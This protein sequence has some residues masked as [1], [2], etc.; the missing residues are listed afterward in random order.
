MPGKGGASTN[1]GGPGIELQ[2]H[3]WIEYKE[4]LD[5]CVQSLSHAGAEIREDKYWDCEE[6]RLEM[7]EVPWWA[8]EFSTTGMV[9]ELDS[10]AQ[11]K[12]EKLAEHNATRTEDD[13]IY[14]PQPRRGPAAELRPMLYRDWRDR[15]DKWSAA[16]T[17]WKEQYAAYKSD[18]GKIVTMIFYTT[19][20]DIKDSVSGDPEWAAAMRASDSLALHRL[21]R[22]H[23][24][25][26]NS[27]NLDRYVTEFTTF[28]WDD[29]ESI[30]SNINR[31]E[32]L[33]RA[34]EQGGKKFT[35]TEMVTYLTR[36][37]PSSLD[38][39]TVLY[40]GK[41]VIEPGDY[42][43]LKTRIRTMIG[44]SIITAGAKPNKTKGDGTR[45]LAVTT[46]GRDGSTGRDQRKGKKRP[47]PPPPP[48]TADLQQK[49]Q[50]QLGSRHEKEPCH[51]CGRFG[52]LRG[53]CQ[54]PIERCTECFS[55]NHQAKYCNP[56]YKEKA[57]K[58][59]FSATN[60]Q[61]QPLPGMSFGGR[62]FAFLLTIPTAAPP[63]TGFDGRG[64]APVAYH[65]AHNA[66][67]GAQ[68]MPAVTEQPD[69]DEVDAEEQQGYADAMET[70][71]YECP[72]AV[73]GLDD[74]EMI[75]E[76]ESVDQ[77]DGS[78]EIVVATAA[79]TADSNGGGVDCDGHRVVTRSSVPYG[80]W[81]PSPP[82]RPPAGYYYKAH[83]T[84][85]YP[86]PVM[87]YMGK[88]GTGS[89]FEHP[90]DLCRKA[91]PH[92]AL[93][94]PLDTM[95]P[96]E[97]GMN[98]W[99]DEVTA[100]ERAWE[101]VR[102][103]TGMGP[104]QK[105]GQCIK[106]DFPSLVSARAVETILTLEGGARP[107]QARKA[108][109]A[110]A[111]MR[112]R[113]QTIDVR[114]WSTLTPRE[115]LHQY[116]VLTEVP[117]G[118]YVSREA[119][120]EWLYW[121]PNWGPADRAVTRVPERHL[122][123]AH[124]IPPA[125]LRKPY[126]H[127]HHWVAANQPELFSLID[128]EPNLAH[129]EVMLLA[130]QEA[131]I[132]VYHG[133]VVGRFNPNLTEADKEE[134]RR[135]TALI[136]NAHVTHLFELVTDPLYEAT[137]RDPEP[138]D[139]S[140]DATGMDIAE[141]TDTSPRALMVM[142]N[143]VRTTAE[144]VYDTGASVHILQ[145]I[146]L[147]R[148]YVRP[149]TTSE[150]E[151]Q[152]YGGHTL[153]ATHCGQ[154][155]GFGTV[156]VAADMP[157]SLIAG[158]ELDRNGYTMSVSRG[159]LR[160]SHPTRPETGGVLGDSGLYTMS[161]ASVQALIGNATVDAR[162]VTAL[163]VTVGATLHTPEQRRR[164]AEVEKLHELL[165]HPSDEILMSALDN[166][167]IHGTHLVS[168][169]V[170]VWRELTGPCPACVAARTKRP[171][172]GDSR[173]PPA[174]VIGEAV[175]VDTYKLA[176][177]SV[178]GNNMLLISVDEFS[179]YINVIALVN[180][181][182]ESILYG[183]RCLIAHYARHGHRLGTIR[184]DHDGV[185]LSCHAALGREHVN[186]LTTNPYQHSQRIERHIQTLLS[187]VRGTLHGLAYVLPEQLYAELFDCCARR[188]NQLPTTKRPTL[189]AAHMFEKEKLDCTRGV[190]LAFGTLVM[191]NQAGHSLQTA[192]SRRSELGIILG[193]SHTAQ[194]SMRMYSIGSKRIL[195]RK[196]FTVLKHF[197]QDFPF[198]RQAATL[199]LEDICTRYVPTAPM[200]QV[201]PTRFTIGPMGWQLPSTG[202]EGG[203]QQPAP[204]EPPSPLTH[205]PPPP[206]IP[207]QPGE[208]V[209][210]DHSDDEIPAVPDTLPAVT[211]GAHPA[212]TEMVP[213]EA[214]A[215]E[216]VHP[217]VTEVTMDEAGP[218]HQN[219]AESEVEQPAHP[220]SGSVCE[221]PTQPDPPLRRSAR[222]SVPNSWYYSERPREA[223]LAAT[224]HIS[225]KEALK[226]EYAHQTKLAV[227]EEIMNMITYQVG[228]YVTIGDIP[229]ELRRNILHTFMFIK[230]KTNNKGQYERT[231]ARLVG[232]GARQGDHMYD[233]VY[234]AT[235]QLS[236]VLLLLNIASYYWCH[237]AS[238]DVKGAFLH[239][240]FEDCDP[241]TYI[242]V[243][244]E[245]A[246]EWQEL[247]PECKGYL[248]DKG[249][250][251]LQLDKFI[252]GLKQSPHKF[253]MHLVR[254][255]KGVGY[256]QAKNDEC[257]FVKRISDDC[258]SY[259]SV[260]VD[261]ILQ[262]SNQQHMVDELREALIKVYKSVTFHPD[263]KDYVGFTIM[264]HGPTQSFHLSQQ[265]QIKK[266]LDE[267]LP[268]DNKP[269]PKDPARDEILRES[270]GKDQPV[271]RLKYLGLIMSLM[272]VARLTRPDILLAVTV[273]ATKSS[274]PTSRDW[275]GGL[276]VARYLRG[277]IT[278]G[279]VLQCL[280][281]CVLL[282]CDSS[283]GIH[284]GGKSHTGF[285]AFMGTARA[286]LASKSGKQKLVALSSTDAEILALVECVKFGVHV[287]ALLA[288]MGIHQSK[289]M[290]IE[291]D[292]ESCIGLSGGETTAKRSK[293]ILPKLAYI[294]E[295]VQMGLVTIRYVPTSIILAD[296]LTKPKHGAAFRR[297]RDI[298]TVPP[299]D[300][301]ETS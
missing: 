136:T 113:A 70:D 81:E 138:T 221:I 180:G 25:A 295:K 260:H 74:F 252:Y 176:M 201:D 71:A 203:E 140:S 130:Y 111:A 39:A 173:N 54:A 189:S 157:T 35:E 94:D 209:G 108:A 244:K 100:T 256:T 193:P 146:N 124:A 19:G 254:T 122:P 1:H 46:G 200:E 156:Y 294:R 278:H 50:H 262:V 285:L 194:G 280:S 226:S 49:R 245:V 104:R 236:S 127:L 229:Q 78:R 87:A 129:Y 207:E 153:N 246:D 185:F 299:F 197:P 85:H 96:G 77:P 92:F 58:A 284:P 277:T 90:P 88:M 147:V 118:E 7:P 247:D 205:S 123:H 56:M 279:V 117:A 112:E 17:K 182:A 18:R 148:D 301:A 154:V 228:H 12:A 272:Y 223:F 53:I 195:T 292:N 45:A 249:E 171:H 93:K 181:K 69:D 67:T 196:V 259:L 212:V 31:F 224:Y 5:A 188:M 10:P 135:N 144:F 14:A 174:T 165:N 293:H 210:P 268:G 11:W 59:G 131:T 133:K 264:R 82:S 158:G 240:E 289:P 20:K 152:A 258:W 263:A 234:S 116:T 55:L 162:C 275:E 37:A 64:T 159:E 175:H 143:H 115:R 42:D 149:V 76:P 170:K 164:A 102:H 167:S 206:A 282:S 187:R 72:Y 57:A 186:L 38:G 48:R 290:V 29:R 281:L 287:V 257:V 150:G 218:S 98:Q 128:P 270:S 160:L 266:V 119:M 202:L 227:R 132:A 26:A 84:Y 99:R 91:T 237:V 300:D 97:G 6:G 75:D 163:A 101:S 231:K 297:A 242:R 36:S 178:G 120:M 107:P 27:I 199:R 184:C 28:K 243:S 255:L 33:A 233:L 241:T 213:P 222:Q 261:D 86:P 219:A 204:A 251:L 109:E 89:R 13:H 61:T 248:T 172:Y 283:F 66:Q 60:P 43:A 267:Y 2:A 22:K 190:P 288:E 24:N 250:L 73:D 183:L 235:V 80:H 65:V 155:P 269:N 192:T 9:L 23:S 63:S 166:G 161:R 41:P 52:H 273:L 211:G 110:L 232:N 296:V 114:K 271:D 238:Y 44:R 142:I 126:I 68:K 177:A 134:A 103:I 105:T 79:G 217:A 191:A 141:D 34:C 286:F 125:Y 83:P 151:F 253:Q 291:Q 40:T 239:A 208:R 230:H 8:A 32:M 16:E 168:G 62:K 137:D 220:E 4:E 265:G 15:T 21:Q 225:V 274:N 139:S 169:D 276:H 95:P 215:S 214:E 179:D 298:L 121:F 51:N 145:D 106:V 216:S 47:A 198:P 30:N 3:N